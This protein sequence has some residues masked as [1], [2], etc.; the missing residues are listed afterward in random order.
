MTCSN[1]L[2][3]LP[4]DSPR[5]QGTWTQSRHATETWECRWTHPTATPDRDQRLDWCPA[6]ASH[7]RPGQ[8][9]WCFFTH[10]LFLSCNQWFVCRPATVCFSLV[11]SV[12][13]AI[14]SSLDRIRQPQ[15]LKIWLVKAYWFV[16][17]F[18]KNWTGELEVAEW[19]KKMLQ[20]WKRVWTSLWA[21][22]AFHWQTKIYS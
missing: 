12:C 14:A 17:Y 2:M 21:S 1:I 16:P 8:T 10:S 9:L 4:L 20:L 11:F 7:V 18:K 5:M 3:Q 6:T 13:T 22:T 15:S 19:W